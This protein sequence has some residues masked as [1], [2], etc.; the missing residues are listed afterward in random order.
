MSRASGVIVL[1]MH[2][3]G[4]SVATQMLT[5]LGLTGP[6]PS[7]EIPAD[8]DNPRGYFESRTLTLLGDEVLLALGATWD[9]PPTVEEVSESLPILDRLMPRAQRA[10]EKLARAEPWVWKDPRTCVLLPFWSRLLGGGEPAVMVYRSARDVATSLLKRNGLP[11][12]YGLALWER[13]TL[14]A[15]QVARGRA[16]HIATY[17][18]LLAD[19]QSWLAEIREFVVRHVHPSGDAR[20]DAQGG[21]LIAPRSNWDCADLDPRTEQ[22]RLLESYLGGVTGSHEVFATRDVPRESPTTDTLIK[23]R[24]TALSEENRS[25]ML[26]ETRNALSAEVETKARIIAD[27]QV[28]LEAS[29]EQLAA[30]RPYEEQAQILAARVAHLERR[31]LVHRVRGFL[32]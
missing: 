26:W 21:D 14:S 2:R 22:Q 23:L 15:L 32:S 5:R 16:I 12:A 4:T 18:S 17:E 13:Y 8:D 24:R 10:I 27:L 19:P 29:G 9:A 1:G 7:D 20:P 28:Q 6:A 3:S 31:S 25:A 30:L 11:L